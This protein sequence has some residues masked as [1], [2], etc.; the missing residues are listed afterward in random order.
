[1]ALPAIAAWIAAVA[2]PTVI[3]AILVRIG[4]AM[5]M[6]VLTYVGLYELFS[7][8]VDQVQL[9]VSS[10][11]ADILAMLRISGVLQGISIVL[12][13]VLARLG[14]LG[15]VAGGVLRKIDWGGHGLAPPA[16]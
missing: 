11:T 10:L 5:G 3:R 16:Q 1:M 7:G 14:M 8:M 15:L 12:S 13:A 4:V 6:T 2:A 9:T